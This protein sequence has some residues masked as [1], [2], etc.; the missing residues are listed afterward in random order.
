M[1]PNAGQF[2]QFLGKKGRLEVSEPVSETRGQSE[3]K[4]YELTLDGKKIG[5]YT[6][7]FAL[8]GKLTELMYE[9]RI[10]GYTFRMRDQE[11]K[12][13]VLMFH[14]SK[15]RKDGHKKIPFP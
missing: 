14:S 8:N 2:E 6:E 3:W 11:L 4:I 13:L 7:M 15:G 1:L 12:E 5:R 10:P 9:G